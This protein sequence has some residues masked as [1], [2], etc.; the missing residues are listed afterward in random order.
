MPRP[1][2]VISPQDRWELKKVLHN[3]P[4]GWS[5]VEG[6]YEGDLVVGIR[7]NGDDGNNPGFPTS[8]GGKPVWFFLP[9][10]VGVVVKALAEVLKVVKTA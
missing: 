2:D 3:D 5:I 10:T 7:W 6:E 9:Y 1:E 4:E 8:R